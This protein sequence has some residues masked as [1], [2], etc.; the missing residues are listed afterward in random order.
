MTACGA[1]ELVTLKQAE[2]GRL[3][4]V[5][6]TAAWLLTVE[7]VMSSTISMDFSYRGFS[8]QRKQGLFRKGF[9]EI[10]MRTNRAPLSF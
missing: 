10:E 6:V 9:W 2:E 7:R 3:K 1:G 8:S 4:T 5:A